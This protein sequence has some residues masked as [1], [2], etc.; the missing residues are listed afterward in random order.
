MISSTWDSRHRQQF[1]QIYS[2]LALLEVLYNL[3]LQNSLFIGV[4]LP[5]KQS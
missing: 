3:W 4:K 2:L 1:I 5:E